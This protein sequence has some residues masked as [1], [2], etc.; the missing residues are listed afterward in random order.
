V[1]PN[2]ETVIAQ[3]SP[4]QRL[5]IEPMKIALIRAGRWR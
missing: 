4:T 1:P 2:I 5:P 3:G